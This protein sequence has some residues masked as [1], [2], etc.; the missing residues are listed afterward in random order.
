MY[1]E[2]R[3]CPLPGNRGCIRRTHRT[4]L[5]DESTYTDPGV[6]RPERFVGDTPEPDPQ[7]V[8]F[9]FGRRYVSCLGHLLLLPILPVALYRARVCP[10][11]DPLLTR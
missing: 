8:C 10:G 4:I 1:G 6:F 9:G 2:Y 3:A 5:H 11:E 7:N